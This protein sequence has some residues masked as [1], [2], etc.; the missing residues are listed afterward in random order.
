MGEVA[1]AAVD[2]IYLHHSSSLQPHLCPSR[3]SIGL[4]SHKLQANPV[5]GLRPAVVAQQHWWPVKVVYDY[6]FV[7][8]FIVIPKCGASRGSRLHQSRTEARSHFGEGSISQ[9]SVEELALAIHSPRICSFDLWIDVSVHH[10][11]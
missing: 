5:T 3:V 10:H 11:Q 6:V 9:V 4:R 7:P 8:V 2:L 1:V